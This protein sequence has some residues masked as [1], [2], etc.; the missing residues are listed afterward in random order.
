M[1]KARPRFNLV[2]DAVNLASR[3]ESTGSRGRIQCSKSTQ[4]LLAPLP[5]FQLKKRSPAI[6]VKGKGKMTTF[7]LAPSSKD[8]AIEMPKPRKL[9]SRR[10]KR[11]AQ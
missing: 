4:E 3:M 7:W 1:G 2:G 8:D 11:R 10:S 5:D 9:V 6:E